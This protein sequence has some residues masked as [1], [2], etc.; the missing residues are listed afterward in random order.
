MKSTTLV[1]AM[2][3]ALGLLALA[4]PADARPYVCYAHADGM[5]C[6]ADWDG[7]LCTGYIVQSSSCDRIV[8]AAAKP[9]ERPEKPPIRERERERERSE[10]ATD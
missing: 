8:G 3:I 10:P 7:N 5:L 6:S 2:G 1:T 9:P 4:T